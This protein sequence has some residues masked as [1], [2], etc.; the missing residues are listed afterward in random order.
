MEIPQPDNVEV[1]L[2]ALESHAFSKDRARDLLSICATIN[3]PKC[4]E[5]LIK[6]GW[7]VNFQRSHGSKNSPLLDATFHGSVETIALLLRNGADIK[8]KNKWKE[9]AEDIATK[10]FGFDTLEDMID[11]E[12]QVVFQLDSPPFPTAHEDTPRDVTR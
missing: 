1:L 8:L 2:D 7:E 3:A 11:P 5:E 12:N 6:A 10:L 4:A 9:T